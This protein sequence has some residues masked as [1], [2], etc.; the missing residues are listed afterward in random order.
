MI[1][2]VAIFPLLLGVACGCYIR[3]GQD[4]HKHTVP[5]GAKYHYT[6]AAISFVAGYVLS[7][8][9]IYKGV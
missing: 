1:Y 9:L 4:D 8:V 2:F 5:I 3:D 6:L 7:L